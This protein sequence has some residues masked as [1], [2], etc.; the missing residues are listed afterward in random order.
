ML[1]N[2]KQHRRFKAEVVRFAE[3]YGVPR[4]AAVYSI[5]QDQVRRWIKAAREAEKERLLRPKQPKKPHLDKILSFIN[6]IFG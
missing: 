4:A 3:R 5:K 1:H 2:R 6:R